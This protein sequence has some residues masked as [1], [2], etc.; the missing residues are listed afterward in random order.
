[1]TL[2][3][4]TKHDELCRYF[5]PDVLYVVIPREVWI[6]HNAQILKLIDS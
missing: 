3:A 4:L 5:S 1:M 6:Q 2:R